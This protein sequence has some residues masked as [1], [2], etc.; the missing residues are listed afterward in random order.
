[1][2]LATSRYWDRQQARLILQA[3]QRPTVEEGRALRGPSQL[4]DGEQLA[5]ADQ[6]RRVEH[7]TVGVKHLGE[8]LR[9]TDQVPA[10]LAE[11]RVGLLHQGTQVIGA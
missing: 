9:A 6:G 3:G 4:A 2:P 7:P 10:A 8:A 1:V 5:A 11:T